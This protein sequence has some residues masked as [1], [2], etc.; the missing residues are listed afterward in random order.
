[1]RHLSTR[2]I[3]TT[4]AAALGFSFIAA[5]QADILVGLESPITGAYAHAGQDEQ[6]GVE[7]A[8]ALYNKNTKGE[9][10]KLITIDDESEPAK[11]IA[12]VEKLGSEKVVAI[13]SGYGSNLTGPASKAADKLGIPLVSGGATSNNL[14]KQGLKTFFQIL[15]ND[16]Y[17]KALA[18]IYKQLGPKTVSVLYSTKEST[19]NLAEELKQELEGSG[20]TLKMH[21]FDSST[22]DYKPLINKIKLQDKPDLIQMMA[23]EN[24]Y[25]AI[26]KAARILK[27][28]VDGVMGIWSLLTPEMLKEHGDIMQGVF[29]TATLGV[30]ATFTTDDGKAFY[31]Q[32]NEQFKR[33]PGYI[34]VY[35]YVAGKVLLDAIG[36]AEAAG[37]VTP[38]S[39]TAEL[40]KTDAETLLGRVKFDQTGF[41][42]EFTQRI[43]QVQGDRIEI[44]WPANAATAK[45]LYP[46]TP[47]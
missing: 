27:P 31:Q 29:G 15:N 33:V 3:R 11:A 39:V 6:H 18:G 37:G 41:N 36:R 7:A 13:V 28:K 35:G 19:T 40:R 4:L 23:Y 43:G 16:G 1:M 20:V 8:V 44:V 38:A 2:F 42:P 24:D 46:K 25:V 30:P 22:S 12:A 47:W 9:K 17:K 10:I 45:P 34:D 26:L 32:F 14:A 5:A 21:A